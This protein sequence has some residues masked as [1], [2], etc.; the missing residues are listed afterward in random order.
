MVFGAYPV[1]RVQLNE[2]TVW[3]GGPI[4]QNNPAAL[5]ALPEVRRLLFAGKVAEAEELAEAKMFGIPRRIKPSQTL[6]DLFIEFE[7]C[8]QATGY[9]RELDLDRAIAMTAYRIDGVE[10]A[11]EVF[12]SAPD[13]VIVTR[14]SASRSAAI[15][16]T[17]R[18]TREADATVRPLG[19]DQLLM[20]GKLDTGAGMRIATMLRAISHSGKIGVA[21]DCLHIRDADELLILLAAATDYRCPNPIDDCKAVLDAASGFSYEMLRNSHIASHQELFRRVQLSLGE[22]ADATVSL[23]TD[24]RMTRLNNGE[25]DNALLALYFHFGRY[26]LI[27]SSGPAATLP[28]NLQGLWNDSLKPA[29]DCDYHLNIN[30]QMNYWPAEVCGLE[31]CHWPVFDFLESLR[32]PGR[33][34][35]RIHYGCGGF[36]VHALT[37]IFGFTVPQGH[38]GWGLWPMG[39]AWMCDDL[40]EHYRFTLDREFLQKRAYPILKEAA[41]FFVDHLTPDAQGRLV[42]GPSLSPENPFV[43]SDGK[44]GSLCMGPTMDLEILRALFEHC[45]EA[46]KLLE[47]DQEFAA[48]LADMLTRLAPLK[49]GTD[50]RLQEWPQEHQEFD[51]GHRHMSHL[52]ALHPGNQ[53]DVDKTPELARA[54]R[55]S[56]E[57][58]LAQGGGQ[59]GWSRAGSPVSTH[60]FEKVNWRMRAWSNC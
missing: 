44:P 18:L 30:L 43:R 53:I 41:E 24:E 27:A 4:E 19:P 16:C 29:W 9:R 17:L 33:K 7:G 6:G 25:A 37:D 50:G 8:D 22:T 21:N 56:L 42:T 59:T 34:T 57:H 51:P 32:Q 12:A 26:L 13:Q 45:I 40:W 11:R 54:A 38:V 48:R 49:I 15:N 39:A 55:K 10:F 23:P 35:A 60:V 20:E 36:V 47:R 3:S 5:E 52:Y 58:R 1:E 28:A 14:F 31:E 2:E 46:A